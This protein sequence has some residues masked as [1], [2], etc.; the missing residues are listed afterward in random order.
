MKP[1]VYSARTRSDP[2]FQAYR[3][4]Y[5]GFIVAPMLA[6]LDKFFNR[7]VDWTIYVAPAV[8]QVVSATVLMR[9]SGVIE[10]AAALLVAFKPRIGA[11]VVAVW[12]W[13]IIANL[14]LIPGHYDIALRDFGLSLGALALARLSVKFSNARPR[15][16]ARTNGRVVR[17]E[18]VE[19]LAD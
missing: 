7:L 5:V 3:I 18:L 9:V 15:E 4:L 10:I 13:G 1:M 11:M 12:L 17:P 8:S 16:G 6:G 2:A 14:L 19:A